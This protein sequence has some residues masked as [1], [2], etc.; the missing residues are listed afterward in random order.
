VGA[1]GAAIVEDRARRIIRSVLLNAPG[2]WWDAEE[3]A[4]AIQ[5]RAPELSRD[6]LA[7]VRVVLR[8]ALRAGET[9]LDWERQ[10]RP[11]ARARMLGK[12]NAGVPVLVYR[13]RGSHA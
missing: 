1:A 3:L 11:S 13:W 8:K 5:E 2:R 6:P 7:V 10:A 12:R 9:W 4:G